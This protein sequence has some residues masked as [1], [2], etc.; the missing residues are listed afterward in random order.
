MRTRLPQGRAEDVMLALPWD[1]GEAITLRAGYRML[2]GGADNDEVYNFA[3][4]SLRRG[5]RDLAT[6]VARGATGDDRVMRAPA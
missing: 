2:E 1:V 6:A 4:I 5:R 3:W